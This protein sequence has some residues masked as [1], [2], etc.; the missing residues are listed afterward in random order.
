MRSAVPAHATRRCPRPQRRRGVNFRG[1]EHGERELSR[2]RPESSAATAALP[3]RRLFCR[4]RGRL[5]LGRPTSSPATTEKFTSYRL[6]LGFFFVAAPSA[7][8]LR[9][10]AVRP[11][12]AH[13]DSA[14]RSRK[15]EQQQA[16]TRRRQRLLGSGNSSSSSRD[17]GGGGD[18]E[19]S[20][21]ALPAP[22]PL[23]PHPQ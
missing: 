23:H 17:L 19:I 7:A 18:L 16:R 21:S 12:Q 20:F 14:F 6:R 4:R 22:A 11:G 3:A 5:G 2:R 8:A 10:S 13:R 15:G 9:A 1:V